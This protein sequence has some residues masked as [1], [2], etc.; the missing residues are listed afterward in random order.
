MFNCAIRNLLI[1]IIS[2]V[3]GKLVGPYFCYFFCGGGGVL[4]G[5][6]TSC[7]P[8]IPFQTQFYISDNCNIWNY[9]LS[10][11]TQTFS[12]FHSCMLPLALLTSTWHPEEH[13][14]QILENHWFPE[15]FHDS[16]FG[17]DS[18]Q[19]VHLHISTLQN[20]ECPVQLHPRHLLLW[21]STHKIY[22]RLKH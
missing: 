8:N 20:H 12:A 7:M 17:L 9:P 2:G 4:S 15:L 11:R 6:S 14:T 10:T 3:V 1:R 19:S 18:S 22:T 21:L 13:G 16:V 5:L